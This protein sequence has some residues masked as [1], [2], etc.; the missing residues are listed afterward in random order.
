MSGFIRKLRRRQLK[1]QL[2]SNKIQEA[3]HSTYDP[4][5]KRFKAMENAQKEKLTNKK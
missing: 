5:W 4:L 3:F 2:G 1:E